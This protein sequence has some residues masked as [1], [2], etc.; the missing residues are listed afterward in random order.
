[1]SDFLARMDLSS[2]TRLAA[3][4]GISTIESMRRRAE[5]V[6]TDGLPTG[7][8]LF[9]EIKPV[10]PAEGS[11][12]GTGFFD[13]VRAYESGGAAA[14]SVLTEPTEFG[15]SLQ[16]LEEIADSTSLPVMRKDF[17][18]DPFQVWE[19]RAHGASGVLAIAR[20]LDAEMLV[21]ISRV[22]RE[23]DMFL[24]V[25][26]FDRS[27]F[28]ALSG[29][30][31][32]GGHLLLGVNSRDLDTLALRPSAHEQLAEMLPEGCVAIAESGIG[33]PEQVRALMVMGYHG[34]LVGTSLMRSDD[35]GA[36]VAALVAAG[37]ES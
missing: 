6:P 3:A 4:R 24:L 37:A 5:M 17:I 28:E 18:V 14:I 32:S 25:E 15:G 9:A 7:F 34:V 22:A 11:L 2:R 21:E 16:L 30:D 36:D 26:A 33:S 8:L 10:S 12:A 23:A 20:L 27:D 1:M 31:F 29:L 35:P 13:L 19:A